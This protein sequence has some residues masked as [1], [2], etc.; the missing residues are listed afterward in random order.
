MRHWTVSQSA[1]IESRCE[2][3]LRRKASSPSPPWISLR[4][5]TTSWRPYAIQAVDGAPS[6]PARPVSW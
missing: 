2:A 4:C 1:S 5:W 3:A 6:R